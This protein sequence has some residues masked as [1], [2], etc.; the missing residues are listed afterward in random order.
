VAQEI[1]AQILTSPSSNQTHALE[2]MLSQPEPDQQI[3]YQS[4]PYIRLCALT[5][6]KEQTE[7]AIGFG[8]ESLPGMQAD[9]I[10]GW[11]K[12]ILSKGIEAINNYRLPVSLV[13]FDPQRELT[14][15]IRDPIGDRSFFFTR[16]GGHYWISNTETCL[17]QIPGSQYR[18]NQRSL[19][20]LAAAA[21]PDAGDTFYKNI[22]ELPPGHFASFNPH[23]PPTIKPYYRFRKLPDV[24]KM[25]FSQASQMT[26]ALC[27]K[28]VE[29][30]L[31]ETKLGLNLSGGMD[32]SVL[33]VCC[34]KL[35]ADA[36]RQLSTYSYQF[37]HFP[38]CDESALS[39]QICS[40][41]G[42]QNYRVNCDQK[43]PLNSTDWFHQLDLREVLSDPYRSCRNALYRRQRQSGIRY[44]M[45]GDFGDH[46]YLG[47]NYALRDLLLNGQFR[48]LWTAIKRIG[49]LQSWLK[50]PY[51]RRL[52]PAVGIRASN[53]TTP[54]WLTPHGAALLSLTQN[55]HEFLGQI[56]R[57]DQISACLNNLTARAAHI[58]AQQVRKEGLVL[59][60]PFRDLD[61]VE[62]MLSLPAHY[63]E[64]PQDGLS[65][66]VMR[67]A[68][69]QELPD[70]ILNR[71]DKTS[72]ITLL[73]N[74]LRQTYR[75]RATKIL[76]SEHRWWS[77]W[78]EPQWLN[79]RL[80]QD[81][82][83]ETELLVIW[84]SLSI[85]IWRQQQNAAVRQ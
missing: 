68:F 18:I 73:E 40:R 25:S 29:K 28:A 26:S 55:R 65:R 44:V 61:L 78:I 56:K 76:Q 3:I 5:D 37:K 11:V 14:Y 84:I 43:L 82:W 23:S 80:D 60:T 74:S 42:I 22:H 58:G 62:F 38:E 21:Y 9:A 24:Y 48:A 33:A 70:G 50:Q 64:R 71:N 46:L 31:P 35:M 4:N 16:H 45:T 69:A 8:Q 7:S 77:S 27:H 6:S 30:R 52:L 41:L 19:A 54:P 32:S 47:R 83:N 57:K 1:I 39:K 67:A 36:P 17:L 51:L 2:A 81:Q 79:T 49:P 12:Q 75:N 20:A 13:I 63:L 34:A 72:L 10:L 66:W 59:L 15:L 85:E 53:K